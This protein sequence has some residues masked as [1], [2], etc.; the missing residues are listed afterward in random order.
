MTLRPLFPILVVFALTGCSTLAPIDS[1]IPVPS[2][3][4]AI[5]AEPS[6]A[7]DPEP[8]P[9]PTPTFDPTAHSLTKADSLW[10]V[11][12]KLRHIRP[13]SYVPRGLVRMNVPYTYDP[14]LRRD[15]AKAYIKMRRAAAEK[16]KNL[17][18][19][20]AYRSYATQ[21]AV[22][23]GWVNQLGQAGA[24]LQSARPGYSEH[25]TG[26]SI[27][28]ASAEHGCTISECFADTPEGRWLYDNAW[29]WGWVLRYPKGKTDI[30]GYRFEP[31]HYRFV[32][33]ALAKEIHNGR[34]NLTLEEYW[35]LPPAP[36]YR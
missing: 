21:V 8:T 19:Q 12:N 6:T 34:R 18:A 29:K 1:G 7:A 17:V 11:V 15:A 28:I 9:T 35:G 2:Q 36:D 13:K 31:W 24:D 16:G 30:T 22:Y 4:S 25:Q 23:N 26:L 27:D 14:T 33:K 32:G 20:S 10:V 5:A 3:D